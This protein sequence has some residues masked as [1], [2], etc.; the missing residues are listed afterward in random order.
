[1]GKAIEL[2]NKVGER[3]FYD[4]SPVYDYEYLV[5]KAL[6]PNTYRGFHKVDKSKPGAKDVFENY[7]ERNAFYIVSTLQSLKSEHALDVL[8]Q[9][10]CKGLKRELKKNI[11]N[12]QLVSYNKLRKPVDIIVEHLISMGTDF[13][14]ARKTATKFL[15]LP[16]DSQMF[17]SK[18]VF[19]DQ[20]VAELKINRR[21]TFKDISS[22]GHYNE[23]QS[24]LNEK[25]SRIGLKNRIFFDLVWNDRYKTKGK[26]LFESN[27]G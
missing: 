14:K 5:K 17:Q 9:E 2:I 20:E 1:M 3:I 19:S 11:D 7:F 16:L 13:L 18:I 12:R 15:F 26:N 23:I 8:E 27:A 21:F 25:A 6:A 24:F 22:E 10:I 4:P